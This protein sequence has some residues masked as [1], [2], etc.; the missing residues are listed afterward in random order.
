MTAAPAGIYLAT[1][2]GLRPWPDLG[3]ALENLNDPSDRDPDFPGDRRRAVPD[4]RHRAAGEPPSVA[5]G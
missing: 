4:R 3:P 5:L 1:I 2:V